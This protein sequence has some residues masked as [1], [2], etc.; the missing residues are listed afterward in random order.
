MNPAKLRSIDSCKEIR[1]GLVSLLREAPTP[2]LYFASEPGKPAKDKA[3][4]K[5][6]KGGCPPYIVCGLVCY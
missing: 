2:D 3:R 5:E 1:R 6:L 4:H